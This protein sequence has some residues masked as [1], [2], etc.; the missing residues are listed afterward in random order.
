MDTL[1]TVQR[2]NILS[3]N[4]WPKPLRIRQPTISKS[5]IGILPGGGDAKKYFRRRRCRS[6]Y[7][8]VTPATFQPPSSEASETV[9][10]ALPFLLYS[11][12]KLISQ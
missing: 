8:I 12:L 6:V 3:R 2:E 1:D 5:R 4:G 9:S 11:A 7:S 10:T